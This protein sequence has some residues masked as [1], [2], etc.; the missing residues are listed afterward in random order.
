MLF[1]NMFKHV[2]MGC[3]Y[4]FLPNPLSKIIKSTVLSLGRIQNSHTIIICA[5]CVH[6]LSICGEKTDWILKIPSF[7]FFF[8]DRVDGVDLKEFR[9]VHM[10]DIPVVEDLLTLKNLL[11]DTEIVNGNIN[12]EIARRS[13]Q[14][15]KRTVR[16]RRFKYQICYIR[17]NMH[18]S[19]NIIVLKFESDTFI[20][21]PFNLERKKRMR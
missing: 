17:N 18:S 13:L 21:G 14:K 20:N 4:V 16:P 12:G 10:K 2:P 5:F 9:R 7:Q 1:S 6:M 11:C 15:Y 3:K 19:T 8:L